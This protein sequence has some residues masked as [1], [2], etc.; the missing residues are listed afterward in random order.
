MVLSESSYCPACNSFFHAPD[1]CPKKRPTYQP[2]SNTLVG[3]GANDGVLEVQ[4][5]LTS[6][7]DL[8]LELQLRSVLAQGIGHEGRRC[9]NHRKGQLHFLG[10]APSGRHASVSIVLDAFDDSSFATRTLLPLCSTCVQAETG[11]EATAVPSGLDMCRCATMLARAPCPKCVLL[12]IHTGLKYEMFKRTKL[13]EDGSREIACRCGKAVT[14]DEMARQCAYCRGIATA[15][16]YGYG[17]QIL[18]FTGAEVPMV[19]GEEGSAEVKAE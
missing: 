7:T 1:T 10:K 12:Q 9:D 2:V 11:L 8:A 14:A 6:N 15:P 17:G 13:S 5:P 4:V 3:N 19:S 18:E 16:F